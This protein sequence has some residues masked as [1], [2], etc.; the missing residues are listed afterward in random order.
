MAVEFEKLKFTRD[1]NSSADFPTYEE[2][3][4]KVRADLQ[5]LHDETKEFIN[6]TLIPSIENMAVPGTG[7]MLADV[8]DPQNKRED[9]YR[10]VED[11]VA[12]VTCETIGAASGAEFSAHANS[13]NNPHKVSAEQVMVTENVV[14][15]IKETGSWSV[16]SVLTHFGNLFNGGNVVYR[17]RKEKEMLTSMYPVTCKWE[18]DKYLVYHSSEITVDDDGKITLVDPESFDAYS[19]GSSECVLPVGQYVYIGGSSNLSYVYK[20]TADT[21]YDI[22]SSGSYLDGSYQSY[23][24]YYN[25]E[26]WQMGTLSEI[27]TSTDPNAYADGYVDA[28]GYTYTEL[29]PIASFVPRMSMAS[30]E[31]TGTYGANNPCVLSFDFVPRLV[32]IRDRVKG[33]MALFFASTLTDAFSASGYVYATNTGNL[34]SAAGY[35]A[36]VTENVL[37]WYGSN[38]TT[39]MNVTGNTYSVGAIG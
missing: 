19:V 30:Y 9:I 4:Q 10:Y 13:E 29:E 1:W 8:Y 38:A 3:E 7:D 33:N 14:N 26:K 22:T 17:W 15:A 25:V 34:A 28:D 32:W 36:S 5:A 35:Y 39:Q 23:G 31:G 20:T 24:N 16:D 18:R 6:E 12:G 37:K 21:T 27:V 11:K 2:N